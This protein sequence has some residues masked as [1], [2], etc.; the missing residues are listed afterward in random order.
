MAVWDDDTARAALRQVFDAAVA[1]ADPR[2]MLKEHRRESR[3]GGCVVVGAGK[4]AAVM[5]A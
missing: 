1:A 5:A 2:V 4:S 3:G